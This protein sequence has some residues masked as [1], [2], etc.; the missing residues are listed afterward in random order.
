MNSN[1]FAQYNI[2]IPKRF[3]D[4]VKKYCKTGGQKS[5]PEF[6]PFERQIDFWFTAFLF[7]VNKKLD[8]VKE[9][10]TYNATAASILDRDPDR[11]SFMFLSILGLTKDFDK[12]ADHK[13]IFDYCLGLA[14]AGFPYLIEILADV[15][16]TPLWAVLEEFE[17]MAAS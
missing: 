15:D 17:S 12:L 14:N 8:P 11:I 9:T 10:D 5:T 3:Q 16:D 1:P 7:G 2:E 6:S 4:A 13:W